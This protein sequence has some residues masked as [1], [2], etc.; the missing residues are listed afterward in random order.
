MDDASPVKN[1]NRGCFAALAVAAGLLLAT[2]P[3][4]WDHW[5]VEKRIP[6]EPFI[7]HDLSHFNRDNCRPH[8]LHLIDELEAG[9]VVGAQAD[10]F[11]DDL[12][13]A[14]EIKGGPHRSYT[15]YMFYENPSAKDNEGQPYLA[16]VVQSKFGHIIR[17]IGGAPCF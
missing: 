13:K 12:E 1:S 9:R 6:P 3:S 17:C 8:I 5:M 2:V 15:T 4:A 11:R 10:Q 14:D 7:L 16:V